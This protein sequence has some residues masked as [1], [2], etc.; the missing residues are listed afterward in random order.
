MFGNDIKHYFKCLTFCSSRKKSIPTPR[1]VIEN[2]KG[3][4]GSWKPKFYKQ[5]MKLN[6]N[7]QGGGGGVGCKTRK[8]SV[9]GGGGGL[10]GYFLELHIKASKTITDHS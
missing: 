2:S 8:P 5:S 7:F 4:G 10:C 9:G 1:K 3:G 6:W